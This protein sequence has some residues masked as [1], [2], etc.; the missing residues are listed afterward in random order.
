M[1]DAWEMVNIAGQNG[2]Q[3]A[4]IMSTGSFNFNFGLK[5]AYA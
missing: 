3:N 1:K 4:I 5:I 2:I